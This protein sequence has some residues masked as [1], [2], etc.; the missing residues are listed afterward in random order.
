MDRS[1]D[2]WDSLQEGLRELNERYSNEMVLIGGVAVYFHSTRL[3]VGVEQTHGVD[4]MLGMNAYSQLSS[5]ETLT[6]NRRLEA[7]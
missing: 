2:G 1:E 3:G 5:E 4:L 7:L 6:H